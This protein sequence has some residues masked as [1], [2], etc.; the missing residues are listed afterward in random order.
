[1][2]RWLPA[3]LV[4]LGCL[5]LAF[6]SSH[7]DQRVVAFPGSGAHGIHAREIGGFILVGTGVAL[8]LNA[9]N[10]RLG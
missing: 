9:R 8:L 4:L 1:M 3:W 10:R 5:F 6:D 7:W 2:R